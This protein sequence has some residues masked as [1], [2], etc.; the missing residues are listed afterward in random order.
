MNRLLLPTFLCPKSGEQL[1]HF[2]RQ[3]GIVLLLVTLITFLK[4]YYH[5]AGSRVLLLLSGST[6]SALIL[7]GLSY[8]ESVIHQRLKTW[9]YSPCR[10]IPYLFGLYLFFFE[11]FWQ[12]AN[13]VREFS[14]TGL[15]LVALFFIGGNLIVSVGYMA[16][17]YVES[18]RKNNVIRYP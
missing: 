17:D 5:G 12:L 11:G 8:P 3:A 13:L 15:L 14:Y 16:M 6:L 18:L 9:L 2:A 4:L 10:Y 7:F 1:S